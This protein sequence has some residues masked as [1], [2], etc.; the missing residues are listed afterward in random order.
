VEL[1][2]QS[3]LNNVT[4]TSTQAA[5]TQGVCVT[6]FTPSNKQQTFAAFGNNE[7]AFSNFANAAQNSTQMFEAST[8]INSSQHTGRA[9][10]YGQQTGRRG[11]VGCEKTGQ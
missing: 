3:H 8:A 1:P 9:A 5:V 4:N 10:T 7:L 6:A 11:Q 2:A